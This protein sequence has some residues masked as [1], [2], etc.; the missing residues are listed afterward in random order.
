MN[1]VVKRHA[2]DVG[3]YRDAV[4]NSSELGGRIQ[5]APIRFMDVWPMSTKRPDA[6]M[7]PP[8]DCLHWCMVG[9]MN[10]W[11]QVGATYSS[12]PGSRAEAR[13]L[14][15]MMKAAMANAQ[16]RE[17]EHGVLEGSGAC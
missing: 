6:H 14:P 2:S 4:R 5:N 9:V 16:R 17:P 13:H 3:R 12:V 8:K 15:V 7:T 10:A 1:E 11:S